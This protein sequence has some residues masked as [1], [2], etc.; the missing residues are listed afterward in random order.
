[1]RFKNSRTFRT[2]VTALIILG[3]ILL[4][5]SGFLRPLLGV[6]MD[7]FV[8]V[9][10]WISNQ[11]MAVYDFFTLP[12]D[13]TDLMA[14][15]AELKNEVSQ[16]QSQI[17]ELQEQLSDADILYALLDFARAKPENA[18][19]AA[20]VIGR[21]PNP[22]MHYLIIDH[23]SDDGI[24]YGMPVVTQQGLVGKVDAVTASAA[25]IQLIND[26]DSSV[27]V[28]MQS[29]DK[30]SQLIGSLTGDLELTMIPSDV[31]LQAGEI[32]LTSGLGG[33]Y[34]ADIVVG[35]V[36]SVQKKESDIF[37]TAIVQSS[38]DFST[39]RAV[40]VITNFNAID[41]DLLTSD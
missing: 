4:A 41:I 14:E 6:I 20:S 17:I 28:R 38:I 21:D 36:S 19:V 40:L 10:G 9:Q 7:P 1:M 29:L 35:Q 13:V 22:F 34:P 12:R 5:F 25:R 2:A 27:N 15:N 31:E 30:E 32:L 16:L 3:V 24:R 37:Q 33:N 18:Y 8:K 11:F 39:L 23:G 26:P